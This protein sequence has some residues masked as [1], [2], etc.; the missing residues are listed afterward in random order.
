MCVVDKVTV[1]AL[2][3]KRP[4]LSHDNKMYVSPASL[5]HPAVTLSLRCYM[6]YRADKDHDNALSKTEF[7]EGALTSKTI[8]QMV[9]GSLHAS[10]SPFTK[11]KHMHHHKVNPNPTG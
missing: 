6:Y 5:A 2:T 7:V 9:L 3:P 4:K 8:Q 1:I 11:R 10:S